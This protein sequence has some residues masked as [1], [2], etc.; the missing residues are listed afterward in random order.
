MGRL[1]TGYG[2]FSSCPGSV[3]I[4][5]DKVLTLKSMVLKF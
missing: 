4:I 1:S 2:I 5:L 3:S